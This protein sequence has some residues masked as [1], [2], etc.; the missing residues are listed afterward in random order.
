MLLM[1]PIVQ[2]ILCFARNRKWR[3][4][5]VFRG[6]IRYNVGCGL[7]WTVHFIYHFISINKHFYIVQ[8]CLRNQRVSKDWS[9]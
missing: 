1:L 4:G 7:I 3:H 2:S 8:E 6:D 5:S 9:D